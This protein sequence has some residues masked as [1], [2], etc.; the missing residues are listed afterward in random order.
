MM[1]RW[2]EKHD[3][4]EVI[5]VSSS[6]KSDLYTFLTREEIAELA[7]AYLKD[8]PDHSPDANRAFPLPSLVKHRR[9]N[10]GGIL[11]NFA[12][13]SEV[14]MRRED[15]AALASTYPP[16]PDP[17]SCPCGCG[18][19]SKARPPVPTPEP[20]AV[21]QHFPC[22][23][24]DAIDAH[25]ARQSE[26]ETA[27]AYSSVIRCSECYEALICA[28]LGANGLLVVVHPVNGCR[29]SKKLFE[30]PTFELK[31]IEKRG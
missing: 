23:E 10:N 25:Y 12:D 1:K 11:L 7:A 17:L 30:R 21:K 9:L 29:H 2:I 22:P 24:C 3:G 15:I 16:T 28:P 18:R 8:S 13:G 6:Q 5:V 14:A 26:P 27:R 31:Q 20:P 4:K 19:V